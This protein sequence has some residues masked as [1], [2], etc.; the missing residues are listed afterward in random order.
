MEKTALI[1]LDGFGINPETRGNAIFASGI[2]Y[3]RSLFD[4]YPKALLK[5][6]SQ[7]VGLPWGEVGNSEV[8]HTTL[9]LGRVVL[10]DLTQIDK[11]FR[12]GQIAKKFT[13]RTCLEKAKKTGRVHLIGLASDG[14]V[15]GHIDH[16]I[17]LSEI[18]ID[19]KIK[20][21]LHLIT[22]GRDVE[23]K[24][25]QKFLEKISNELDND[26]EIGS[27]QGRYFAMDRDKNY[28]RIEKSYR[29]MHGEPIFSG[30][31]SEYIKNQYQNNISDEYIE[32]T[33]FGRDFSIKDLE[34]I[35]FTNFRADRALQ[36][37]RAFIDRKFEEFDR[38]EKPEIFATMTTYEDNLKSKVIFS[39]LDLNNPEINPLDNSLPQIL[40][41]NNVKQFHVAETEKF[42][43]VTYF[44]AGGIKDEFN[45]HKNIIVPSKKVKSYDLY[46]QMRAKEIAN[47]V[48][49]AN[50]EGYS[51]I[52]A[53]FANPDMVGHSGD[54]DKTTKAIKIL[55]EVLKDCIE[56]LINNNYSIFLTSDHGNADE[57][58]NLKSGKISKE[59]SVNP[60]P[61]IY[62]KKNIKGKYISY[63]EAVGTEPV[64]ILSD[65]ATTILATMEI[66]APIE[67]S[68]IDL[69][70]SLI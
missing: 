57:M 21:I 67:M 47:H 39:N 36:L 33:S 46:P 58:L 16:L 6:S 53:N 41:Q 34:P 9:G 2:P 11:A 60:A 17:K 27:I 50:Q 10:Q 43:H 63:D 54:F 48:Q 29:A 69:R 65:V 30:T 8:G 12:T 68:G 40:S 62:I 26:V 5:T 51:F 3:I 25:I 20:P 70:K 28:D 61:F 52:V 24:S 23:E 32:P 1:I 35:I 15:H 55:D 56:E 13:I 18:F 37:T 42:A 31:A 19:K 45:L 44:F 14:A 22:D 4:Q 38:K 59:H 49:R 64:G 7:E 66:S